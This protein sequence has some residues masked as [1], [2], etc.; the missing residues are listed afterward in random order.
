[1]KN[2]DELRQKIAALSDEA[3]AIHNL[4]EKETRDL[5]AEENTRFTAIMAKETGEL[6]KLNAELA[7]AVEREQEISR[8]RTMRMAQLQPQADQLIPNAS[9][10]AAQPQVF[11]R[12]GKL[13]AFSGPDAAADAYA[14]GQWLKALKGYLSGNRDE[15]AEQWISSRRG[16]DIR[17]TATEGTPSAGG[18][19]TPTPL[20]NAVI[21]VRE[22]TGVSRQVSRVL[23][24]TAN[25]L[26]VPQ[27]T[28]GVT[29]YYP[30]EAG[31]STA[32]D[33]T[34]GNVSLSAAKR[35][36]LSYV[37]QELVDDAIIPIMDDL[38]SQM[39]TEFAWQ[40]DNELINGDG[41]STYGGETGILA[42]I[43]SSAVATAATGLDTW[44]ELTVASHS[45]AMGK[46]DAKWL[47]YPLAWICSAQYYTQVMERLMLEAGGNQIDHIKG[48]ANGSRMFG[49]YQVYLTSKMPTSTAAATVCALFG[50]FS[51]SIIIG[52]RQGIR[53]AMSDQFAFDTDRLAIRAT[54][55]YDINV[56]LSGASGPISAVKTAA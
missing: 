10:A 24:M 6:D 16:W 2:S 41:T 20:S 27:K 1:M 18:Y 42:L 31:S 7:S 4:A 8:L 38:A 34:W 32:S 3:Q 5:N 19:L 26:D 15:Q 50:A 53:V 23:P 28:D 54:A 37:S 11:H 33:Q 45:A 47:N 21:D 40:E 29:V 30:G 39:G 48:G 14:S 52:D 9:Q 17:A 55:R 51:Q 22:A 12:L 13:R 44:A 49:G 35:S 25:T 36:I 43:N 56:Y 46:L